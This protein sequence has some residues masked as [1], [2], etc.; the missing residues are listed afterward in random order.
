MITMMKSLLER[1]ASDLMSQEVLTIPSHLSLRAAAHEL[2]RAG[3][4]GAPVTD[5]DGRC[6]GV[7]SATDM[8]HR[9][10]RGEQGIRM[11][12]SDW[13]VCSDWQIIDPDVLPPES[14][15]GYMTKDVVTAAPEDR[16]GDLA[17]RMIDAHIHRII[18]TDAQRRPVGI[19]SSTDILAAVAEEDR[20]QQ[21]SEEAGLNF[22]GR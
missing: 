7:L 16:L 18:I 17:R 9:L 2:A 6:I 10:D 4:S 1:R 22:P 20:L 3:I 12:N 5:D 11:P 13:C 8:V 19:V 15:L 14:V 21:Q